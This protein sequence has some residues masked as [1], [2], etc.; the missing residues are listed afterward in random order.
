L[1]RIVEGISL[2]LLGKFNHL[3][4]QRIIQQTPIVLGILSARMEENPKFLFFGQMLKTQLN[5]M[6]KLDAGE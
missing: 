6:K 1:G 2:V 4:G 5:G 3:T